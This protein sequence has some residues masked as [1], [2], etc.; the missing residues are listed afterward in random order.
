V[1]CFFQSLLLLNY[2]L[3]NGSERVVTSTR[4]HMYDLRQLEDYVSTDEFGRDQGV[5]GIAQ[6]LSLLFYQDYSSYSLIDY[7]DKFLGDGR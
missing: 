6:H 1:K 2:L 5:N 4:E 7:S 3:R